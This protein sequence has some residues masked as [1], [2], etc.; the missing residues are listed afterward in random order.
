[1]HHQMPDSLYALKRHGLSAQ[2]TQ[3]ALS[4]GIEIER[5][6]CLDK[7][8]PGLVVSV[9]YD[10]LL[11][12]DRRQDLTR[13]APGRIVDDLLPTDQR[14]SLQS[15]DCCISRTNRG[16]SQDIMKLREKEIFPGRV[17]LRAQSALFIRV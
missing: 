15:A 5:W 2:I 11:F 12:V 6:F 4:P 17:Q 9:E 16:T 13:P 1:M 10:H 7:P 3:P 14:S 8:F